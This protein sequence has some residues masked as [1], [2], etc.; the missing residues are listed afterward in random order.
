MKRQV[1]VSRHDNELLKHVEEATGTAVGMCYQC[2]K[3]TGG[4]P[5][6]AEHPGGPREVIRLIQLGHRRE[7]YTMAAAWRCVG[8]L[9]CGVRCP[10][11]IDVP[12]VM[13]AVRQFARRD[14][15][16]LDEVR[17]GQRGASRAFPA[18]ALA[19]GASSKSSSS[20][21]PRLPAVILCPCTLLIR[22]PLTS[23]AVNS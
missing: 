12:K 15:A 11:G 7:A 2:G 10:L 5:V 13:D 22:S 19:T 20:T 3:C 9:T 23:R 1:T 8:C 6:C 18:S 17:V 4:C 16:K 21:S 14:G